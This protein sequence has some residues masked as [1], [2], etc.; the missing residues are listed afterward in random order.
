MNHD[1][2]RTDIGLTPLAQDNALC[3]TRSN[4]HETTVKYNV[5]ISY[6]EVLDLDRIIG[7]ELLLPLIIRGYFKLAS[8]RDGIRLGTTSV[9]R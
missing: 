5:Q 7:K 2:H 1:I 3:V 9:P 8:V 6:W 4:L